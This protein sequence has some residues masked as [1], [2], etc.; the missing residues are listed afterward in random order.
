MPQPT[1]LCGDCKWICQVADHWECHANPPTLD[2]AHDPN[3]LCA[4]TFPIVDPANPVTCSR[5]K[6]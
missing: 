4:W 5:Y 3:R 6:D 1:K 2:G